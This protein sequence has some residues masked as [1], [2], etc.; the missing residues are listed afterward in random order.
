M[1][2]A[3]LMQMLERY[4]D[5]PFELVFLVMDPGYSEMNSAKIEENARTL[6][7]IL[8]GEDRG[9]NRAVALLNAGAAIFT[10][11]AARDVREGVALAADSVDSGRA[12]AKLDALVE[13]SKNG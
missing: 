10:Y 5:F 13:I 9:P 6:R 4:S 7:A 12:A 1:L 2:L 11:G 3:K 8:S